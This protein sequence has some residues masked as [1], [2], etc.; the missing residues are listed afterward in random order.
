MKNGKKVPNCVPKEGSDPAEKD[1]KTY[2]KS[3]KKE[4]QSEAA[5]STTG[6]E[7][8][9]KLPPQPGD[10]VQGSKEVK[11]PIEKSAT[12]DQS[13]LDKQDREITQDG[14]YA[15]VHNKKQEKESQSDAASGTEKDTMTPNESYNPYGGVTNPET[16]KP[17]SMREA[18][19]MMY[20]K[21]THTSGATT[22]EGMM[23]KVS[24]AAKAWA[25]KHSVAT[26]PQ[27]DIDKVLDMNKTE[28]D[29]SLRRSVD[30]RNN[31][32]QIG[33]KKP[34]GNDGK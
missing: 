22:P 10:A 27:A 30:Y 7:P 6:P 23:D 11:Q 25:E 29:A 14:E 16:R 17:A 8:V 26:P 34:V 19:S 15:I 18:L 13:K 31:D 4:L 33:D 9:H 20:A 32:Q 12:P 1:S 24:P 21:T 5:N 3:L 2:K 28:V